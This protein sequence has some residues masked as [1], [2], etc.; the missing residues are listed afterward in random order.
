MRN[1]P[2]IGS[3][4]ALIAGYWVLK[5]ALVGDVN[6]ERLVALGGMY[7]WSALT[8]L[9]AGWAIWLVRR[10]R[11]TLSF[12]GDFKLLAK[13]AVVYALLASASVFGWNHLLARETVELRKA[14]RIA[15]IEA[16]TASDSAFETFAEKLPLDQQA[17][18]PERDSYREQALAQVEWM[19]SGGVTLVLSLLTYLFAS[20]VLALGATL[21]VHHIWG[22][23][24]LR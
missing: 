10:S 8:V 24:S 2:L 14:L 21:L 12:W 22:V 15:Q 4:L 11:S 6:E 17:R 18:L 7:H 23:S 20:V 19:H 5:Y 9:T 13:P 16:N 1:R 3:S